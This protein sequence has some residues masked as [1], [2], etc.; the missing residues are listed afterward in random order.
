MGTGS[1]L[2]LLFSDLQ[3]NLGGYIGAYEG[4]ILDGLLAKVLLTVDASLVLQ[5]TIWEI[6]LCII[7]FMTTVLIFTYLLG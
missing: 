3:Y 1:E 5:R 4:Q 6:T 2:I 7:I